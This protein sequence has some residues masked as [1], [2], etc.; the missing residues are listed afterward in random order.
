MESKPIVD[1][2]GIKEH[3]KRGF[4]ARGTSRDLGADKSGLDETTHRGAIVDVHPTSNSG[5]HGDRYS[6]Q[7][8]GGLGW[9]DKP[10]G[11]QATAGDL[12]SR[13]MQSSLRMK[14]VEILEEDFEKK[15]FSM[16]VVCEQKFDIWERR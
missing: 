15:F 14:R 13:S 4:N 11:F 3:P 7:R 10:E 1:W 8:Q 2:G 16:K 12:V 9:A 5:S 6:M